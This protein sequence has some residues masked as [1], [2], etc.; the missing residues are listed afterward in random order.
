M[1]TDIDRPA[2]YRLSI[3]EIEQPL[4]GQFVRL[5]SSLKILP[6]VFYQIAIKKMNDLMCTMMNDLMCND[7]NK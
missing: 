2:I 1:T 7:L 3:D 5:M 4:I 6:Q